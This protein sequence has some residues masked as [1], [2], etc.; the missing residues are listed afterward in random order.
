MNK[1]T[2]ATARPR[3]A[4]VAAMAAALLFGG[5]GVGPASADGGPSISGTV[6]DNAGAPVAGTCVEAQDLRGGRYA[7][8][9]TGADGTYTLNLP[10]AGSYVVDFGCWGGP[11]VRTYWPGQ[12]DQFAA[13]RVAV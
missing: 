9:S 13:G 3:L 7:S 12:D 6:L 11:W 5:G 1:R 4:V 8:G 10:A 2:G